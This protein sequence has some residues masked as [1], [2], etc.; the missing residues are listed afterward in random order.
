MAHKG[1]GI[2]PGMGPFTNG[3]IREWLW[4]FHLD[5]IF[6]FSEK[7]IW[8]EGFCRSVLG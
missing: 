3:A 8:I 5:W 1:E 2:Q 4:L 7:P 6:Y